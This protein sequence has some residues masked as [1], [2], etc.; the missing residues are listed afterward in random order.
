MKKTNRALSSTLLSPHNTFITRV[1][2]TAVYKGDLSTFPTSGKYVFLSLLPFE[3][4]L[5]HSLKIMFPNAWPLKL[6]VF[7]HCLLGAS[8]IIFH[9]VLFFGS[10]FT[11][12]PLPTYAN[13]SLLWFLLCRSFPKFLPSTSFAPQY[14]SFRNFICPQDFSYALYGNHP[15]V[16]LHN[17]CLQNYKSVFAIAH[18][19]SP[20]H[21]LTTNLNQQNCKWLNSSSIPWTIFPRSLGTPR[22]SSNFIYFRSSVQNFSKAALMGKYT[23]IS[24]E[25]DEVT[26]DDLYLRKTLHWR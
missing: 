16:Y 15:N 9:H 1:L 23:L 24:V 26:P 22:Q 10:P 21:C 8:S 4:W 18:Q 12:V 6:P 20:L 3:L 11:W 7:F 25:W 19:A 5:Y 14:F 17:R 2:D 13:L